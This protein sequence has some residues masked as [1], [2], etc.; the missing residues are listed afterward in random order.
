MRWPNEVR[1]AYRAWL[2]QINL[3]A[4]LFVE[5]ELL[6]RLVTWTRTDAEDPGVVVARL[7][8]RFMAT[9]SIRD[10]E[11]F[12]RRVAS[13]TVDVADREIARQIKA[14]TGVDFNAALA[15]LERRIGGFVSE[16]VSLIKS[17]PQRYFSGIEQTIT[18]GVARGQR[19][20]EIAAELTRRFNV[21]ESDAARIARDQVGKL[22]GDI[23]QAKQQALGVTRY[24]WRTVRDNRVREEH[25][26]LEGQ[27]FSWADPPEDGHPGDAINCRCSAEPVLEDI[28]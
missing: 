13:R 23:Q 3:R 9:L 26:E 1:V 24:I 28:L 12:L 21:A 8:E 15:G 14:A 7:A 16:N 2:R 20:E 6:P 19:S 11:A 18:R 5:R 4:R 22:Y 17:V 25:E 10:A 27:I